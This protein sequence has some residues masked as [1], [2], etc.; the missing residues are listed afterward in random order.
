[1]AGGSGAYEFVVGLGGCSAGVT[2]G[3]RE[4]ACCFPE[5]TLGAPETAES[6]HRLLEMIIEWSFGGI[7][8]NKMQHYKAW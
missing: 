2:D 8:I 6:K 4:D 1:M 7:A 5:A 3:R